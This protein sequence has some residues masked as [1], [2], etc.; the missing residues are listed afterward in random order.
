MI[1]YLKVDG[2]RSLINFELR[3]SPGLN[4]LVGP[5]GSGKTNIITFFEFLS[6]LIV[7]GPSE[8]VNSIGGAGSV[9]SKIGDDE[10]SNKMTV[11]IQ[12]STETASK[13]NKFLDYYYKFCIE[14]SEDFDSIKLTNQ[15]LSLFRDDELNFK[16]F[17]FEKSFSILKTQADPDNPN[18]TIKNFSNEY[19][20][21]SF[22]PEKIRNEFSRDEKMFTIYLKDASNTTSDTLLSELSYFIESVRYILADLRGGK[23]FNI[24]PSRV[25]TLEESSNFAGI[26]KEGSGLAA[27]LY[28]IKN[29]KPNAEIPKRTLGPRRVRPQPNIKDTSIT[30]ILDYVK[31]ANPAVKKLDVEKDPFDNSLK[32]FFWIEKGSQATASGSLRG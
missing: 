5:N 18:I 14:A 15:E 21:G 16:E 23:V 19:I 31:I 2:F 32:I 20:D 1:T 10:F 4:V 30:R 13:T 6:N 25:K 12:G 29:R 22:Y 24:N 28:A 3:L 27:T 9:F 11:E 8:A 17:P 26:Q 7:N